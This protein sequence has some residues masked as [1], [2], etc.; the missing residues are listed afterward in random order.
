MSPTSSEGL[1]KYCEKDA[2]HGICT[3]EIHA[4]FNALVRFNRINAYLEMTCTY[5]H[6]IILSLCWLLGESDG[7]QAY[8]ITIILININYMHDIAYE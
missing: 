7:Q 8:N 4:C 6:S 2:H 1:S 3:S 5:L